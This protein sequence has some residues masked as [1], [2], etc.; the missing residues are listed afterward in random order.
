MRSKEWL[1]EGRGLETVAGAEL[2]CMAGG[3]YAS[4]GGGAHWY[5]R[6]TEGTESR[7]ESGWVSTK[8]QRESRTRARLC[9][10]TLAPAPE[11][12]TQQKCLSLS[13][14]PPPMLNKW[15]KASRVGLDTASTATSV[16][17]AAAKQGTKL[18]VRS[19]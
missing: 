10:L 11:H 18:G 4:E 19:S 9:P 5:T 16:G 12:S 8:R 14:S 17:F 15:D 2:G 7:H 13:L 3:L 6:G 1:A